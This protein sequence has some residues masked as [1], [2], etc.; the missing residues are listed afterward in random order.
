MKG[1]IP[2]NCKE[3]DKYRKVFSKLS[4]AQ[5]VV[6]CGNRIVDLK[7]YK[8]EI[9]KLG[10]I[11]HQGLTKV[12]QYL[13]SQV[14]FPNMDKMIKEFGKSYLPCQ[15]LTP[16]N[17]SQPEHLSDLSERPWQHLAMD[18]KGPISQYFYY[19]LVID[20][21]SL[22]P[23]VEIVDTTGSETVLPRLDRILGTNGIPDK[24]KSHN[25]LPFNSYKMNKYG[26]KR[27]FHDQKITPEHPKANSLAENRRAYSHC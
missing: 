19:F 10:H 23:E 27:E 15:A 12:K 3:L 11:G 7:S 24:T 9:V 20:E 26:K 13:R 16:F 1:Y 22:L 8:G 14:W 5:D 25:G 21:S 6:F 2:K 18:F 17:E 4:I